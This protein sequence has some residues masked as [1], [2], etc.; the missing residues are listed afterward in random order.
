MVASGGGAAG[1]LPNKAAA[2]VKKVGIIALHATVVGET[3][4]FDDQFDIPSF[5]M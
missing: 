5:S 3:N 2:A 4:A 1:S